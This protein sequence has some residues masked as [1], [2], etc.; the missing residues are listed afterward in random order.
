MTSMSIRQRIKTFVK[1]RRATA[2][3][4]F[5]IGAPM[6]L[7]GLVIMTDIG[8]AFNQQMNLDQAIR[9]GAEFVMAEET[10]D[11]DQIENLV[12][13]AAVG[14]DP[15]NPT[16]VSPADFPTVEA[17]KSCKCPGSDVS[18]SCTTLCA[19]TN[20]PP[21]IYYTLAATQNYD[22]IF[23][24]DFVLNTQIRVQVR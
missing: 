19:P 15:D 16:D 6:L 8:L 17:V 14:D 1:N 13:A 11:V 12:A 24:P 2:G 3:V 10:D 23:L 7:G 21:S 5:A 20:V 22:A 18:A 9:S 4:E